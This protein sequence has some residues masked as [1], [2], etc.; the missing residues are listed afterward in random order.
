MFVIVLILFFFSGA[1]ALVYEVVWSKYLVL[2]FGSTV[3]AQTIVL[4]VF[5]V[6]LA[7]GSHLFGRWSNILKKPLKTYGFIEIA[8]GIY[9]LFFSQFYEWID[10]LFVYLGSPFLERSQILLLL[11]GG[12]SAIL[13]LI[14]TILMGGTL[15]LLASWLQKTSKD[16]GQW[17]S[18]CYALNTLGAVAGAGLA[19]FFLVRSLGMGMTLW[20][21][22]LTNILIG[23]LAVAL[24]YHQGETPP[25]NHSI[26]SPHQLAGKITCSLRWA[27]ILVAL[28]GG[29][30]MG[31][32]IIFS[33][34][35][36]LV[37]GSSL[38]AF[39]TM[40]MAFIL[41]IGIGSIIISSMGT[42][43]LRI[44]K[45]TSIFL[46][47][48][49]CVLGLFI[50]GIEKWIY[51]YYVANGG[52]AKTE[53]GYCYHQFL[54]ALVSLIILGLPAAILGAVLP[55]W[56]RAMAKEVLGFSEKIGRL[57][58]IN[59]LGCVI[60]A[61][62]TGFVLMPR[63][64]LMGSLGFMAI[65]LGFS[66]MVIAWAKKMR[67]ASG[68]CLCCMVLLAWVCL[69]KSDDWRY[70]ISSGLFRMKPMD[71]DF[72]KEMET[73]RKYTQLLFYEDAA[74]ATVSVER[75]RVATKT[76]TTLR[77]NGKPDASAYGDLSTQYLLAHLPMLARPESKDVFVLGLGSGITAGALLGHPIEH[78]AIAENCEPVLRA[79]SFFEPWNR[80][81]L[82]DPHVQV[83]GEDARTVLKL[84]PKRYD[85][86]I[87]EPSNPWMIGVGSVFSR[88]FYELANARLKE[89]GIFSQWFH[90]YEM[91]DDIIM[92]VLRTF[93]SVFPYIEI[94]DAQGGDI[95]FLG[96]KQPWTSNP[97]IYRNIFDR[98][99]PRED[100]QR[101]GLNSPEAIWVRQLASQHTAFAIPGKGA[102]Q[103]DEIPILEYDAA[104]AAYMGITSYLLIQF[105]ERT[106]QSEIAL[107]DKHKAFASLG[108]S[109]LK[110]IFEQYSS[111]NFE[112]M[113]LI[114][115]RLQNADTL[116]ST[117]PLLMQSRAPSLFGESTAPSK[118]MI[119]EDTSEDLKQFLEAENLIRT[120]PLKWQQGVEMVE[121]TLK[122]YKPSV[123]EEGPKWSPSYFAALA[124]KSSLSHG[125]G[126]RA[127]KILLLGL[128][129]NPNSPQ[130][131]YLAR[132]LD[133]K[134]R[135]N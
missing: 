113:K 83:W 22:G 30:S 107:P 86:I 24:A 73:R 63:L 81:V 41:G 59:T 128:K 48:A 121:T 53:I 66:A 118:A 96:S 92:L 132:I 76:E 43:H 112:L 35:L 87:S 32:E 72:H 82:Q 7:L 33:R 104:K 16:P 12:L 58:A 126:E 55:L 122:N 68:I 94:W 28:S 62:L 8:I 52:L 44:E 25:E 65:F 88:E 20:I 2:M 93:K 135:S 46:L 89:G 90:I 125:D 127:K 51:V 111:S 13:L 114:K 109:I 78:L 36:S 47:T 75:F 70:V 40:L 14:P 134:E 115:S 131:G 69:T 98:K 61:L 23:L 91:N 18:R 119:Q 17:T 38:Q 3:Q 60:G 29:V 56:M 77:I 103:S 99:L 26:S 123:L 11:K 102:I 64:G 120:T 42:Q 108:H 79:S 85:I 1:A 101:I 34:L 21:T 116:S 74:D 45:I 117:G 130:L 37:F 9:G 84:S 106:W 110:P 39:A 5:M 100:L 49:A 27:C 6:G 31:L 15:P 133:A 50:W 71:L 105:D 129:L 124:V 67:V 4:A 95:I 19:G 10:T 97:D 80:H 54:T 57:L